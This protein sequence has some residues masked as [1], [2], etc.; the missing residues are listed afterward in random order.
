[1]GKGLGLGS[2]D[3]LGA[4]DRPGCFDGHGGR[5]IR[6]NRYEAQSGGVFVAVAKRPRHD[7]HMSHIRTAAALLAPLLLATASQAALAQSQPRSA[8][9][10][11]PLPPPVPA[12]RDVPFPGMITLDIDATDL[13]RALYKVTETVPV[14]KGEREMILQ[15]PEWLPGD[16]GP[17]GTIN[18]IGDLHFEVDGKEVPWRRDTVDVYAFHVPLPDG[19]KRVTVRFVHTS[20]LTKGEGRITMTRE[21]LNLQW[22]K[23]SLYPAGY[24]VRQIKVTP[25]VT[26][27]DDWT[28]Y[29]ALDGKKPAGGRGNKVTWDT[30]AYDTLVDSPIFAG[31]YAQSWDI[32]N[33]I[34]LDVVADQARL[35]AITPEHLATF[36]KLSDEARA[37]FGKRHFDHY[38]LLLALTDRMGGIG[39]EHHRSSENQFEPKDFIDWDAMGWDRNV[40]AHELTHSWN[41]KYRRPQDLWTPD[42]RQPMQDS[43]L[44]MYEGQTQLWG[45]VLAARSGVQSKDVVLGALASIAAYYSNEP[46]RAWRSVQDTTND[47]IVNNRASRPYDS[48]HRDEDYYN[49]GALVWLEADQDHPPGNRR[50]EGAGGFRQAVLRRA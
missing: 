23:M 49:E 39:L 10:A 35:L 24:Y 40:V 20:P 29:T 47:P 22:E 32:G 3:V 17:D 4:A 30:V 11:V 12:A 8:P 36:R 19:A 33:A 26:F 43:G 15:L 2:E 14:P 16:H 37:L 25:T 44:W 27:P 34:N 9:E 18:L 50:P 21:M 28:V 6:P 41:G 7:G 38:D 1:M 45:Y 13:T 31:K 5:A 42:Y 46:G 48:L